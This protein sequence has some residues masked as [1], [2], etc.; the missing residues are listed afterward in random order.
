M[1]FDAESID[2]VTGLPAC[3]RQSDTKE[4]ALSSIELDGFAVGDYVENFGQTA[5][6]FQVDSDRGLF[7]QDVK[8]GQKWLADPAK[9]CHSY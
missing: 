9:C 4:D 1:V 6:I 3:I 7:V 8:D 5:R 2:S